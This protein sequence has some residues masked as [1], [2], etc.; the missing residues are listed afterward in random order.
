VAQEGWTWEDW[1]LEPFKWCA[2]KVGM[3]WNPVSITILV[4]AFIGALFL[5]FKL[6]RGSDGRGYY[7]GYASPEEE[8]FE[9]EPQRIRRVRRTTRAFRPRPEVYDFSVPSP[10]PN[11]SKLRKPLKLDLEMAQDLFIPKIRKRR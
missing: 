4:L 8:V 1:L 3:D 11:L 5:L 2:E 9:L 6:L 10:E 7:G